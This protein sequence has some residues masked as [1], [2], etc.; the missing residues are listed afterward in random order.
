MKTLYKIIRTIASKNTNSL[1][2]NQKGKPNMLKGRLNTEELN[3]LLSQMY[4]AENENLF[5]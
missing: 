3:S 5:I 1:F 2:Q 4:S